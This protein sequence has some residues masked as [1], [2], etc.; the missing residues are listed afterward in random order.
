MFDRYELAL[1]REAVVEHRATL[2]AFLQDCEEGD[3]VSNVKQQ[4]DACDRMLTKL[5][6]GA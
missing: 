4:L 2:A 6:K 5:G 1:I 3:E